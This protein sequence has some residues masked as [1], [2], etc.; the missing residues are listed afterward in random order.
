MPICTTPQ[1]WP[2]GHIQTLNLTEAALLRLH[3][4]CLWVT[5][6]DDPQDH[7]MHPGQTL[8]L[9]AG[10][11]VIEAVGSQWAHYDVPQ[12][13]APHTHQRPSMFGTLPG[14]LPKRAA[15]GL[16]FGARPG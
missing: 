9:R 3:A 1:A 7:F 5:Q 15:D 12:A 8:V 10:R 14:Q 16:R 13:L 2:P 11:T 4:G 6:S